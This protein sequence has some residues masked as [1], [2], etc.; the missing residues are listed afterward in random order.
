[1]V[2]GF[3]YAMLLFV[4]DILAAYGVLLFLGVWA[5]RWK[6]RTLLIVAGL[7]FLLTAL[8]SADSLATSSDP[9]D[10]SMLPPDPLSQFA[11]RIT[12]QP[13]VM[14]LGP[15]GFA[16]PFLIGVWAGRRRILERPAQ[17]LALPRAT[18]VIGIGVAVFGA[19]PVSLALAKVMDKPSADTLSLIGP[20]HDAAGV[21]GGLGPFELLIR[22]FTYRTARRSAVV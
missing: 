8:P 15:I 13:L 20:L 11:E 5:L 9:P 19:Q 18:A 4:G 3:L 14:L 21:F 16:T 22:H 2:L 17:H 6:D 7:F 10:P 1:V 12:V